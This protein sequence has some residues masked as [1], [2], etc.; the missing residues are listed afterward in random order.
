M[1][2][3]ADKKP[4]TPSPA[5]PG[6][7]VDPF[8]AYDWK[9]QILGMADA[10]FKNCSGINVRVETISVCEGGDHGSE[11]KMPGRISHASITLERGL[12]SSKELWDWMQSVLSRPPVQRKT[13]SI[14]LLAPDGVTEQLRYTL[15]D[16]WPC[17]YS[18]QQLN[19]AHSLIAIHALELAYERLDQD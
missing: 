17:A 14:L 16:A 3:A 8:R 18:V 7:R 19:S 9:V 1:P 15:H 12:T 11:R 5:T 2:A 4:D 6:A 13:V 10:H